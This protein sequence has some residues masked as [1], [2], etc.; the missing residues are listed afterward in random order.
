[1][2][3]KVE[4]NFQPCRFS[5]PAISIAN[6]DG[7]VEL[8]LAVGL[9]LSIVAVGV[10][11][12]AAHAAINPPANAKHRRMKTTCRFGSFVAFSSRNALTLPLF[13][14]ERGSYRSLSQR[15]GGLFVSSG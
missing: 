7:A 6:G 13:V 3:I 14:W 1:M 15:E 5:H 11:G 9:S 8:M 4:A 12:V 10:G 2:G